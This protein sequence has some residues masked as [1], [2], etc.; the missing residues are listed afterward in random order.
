LLYTTHYMEEVERLADRIVIID[1]GKVIADDTLTDCSRG[2]SA[3]P[4]S[5]ERR[6]RDGFP[7]ADR[8]EPARLMIPLLA[9]IRKD[10]Q[11]FSATGAR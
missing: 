4:S 5:G 1:H 3:R 10:L 6:S 7:D 8:K 9:M 11:L 2:S